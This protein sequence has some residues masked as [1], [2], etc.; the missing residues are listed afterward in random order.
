MRKRV[1]S[2]LLAMGLAVSAIPAGDVYAAQHEV[3]D[4]GENSQKIQFEYSTLSD[5]TIEITSYKGEAGG[6]LII[7]EK[8]DGKTVTRIGT[9]AFSYYKK[10]SGGFKGKL[11]L[12]DNLKIIGDGAFIGC[13]CRGELKLPSNLTSIGENAFESCRNFYGDLVIPDSLKNI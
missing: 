2:L 9:N 4:V 11:I 6:D 5:G 12:P 8:I 1:L 3:Q 7:P 13:G 10:S